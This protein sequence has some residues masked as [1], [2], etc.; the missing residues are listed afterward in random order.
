MYLDDVPLHAP[1][2]TFGGTENGYSISS[3]NDQVLRNMTLMSAAPPSAFAGAIG[4]AITAK[5]RDGSRD[6]TSF[7]GSI[8]MSDVNLLGEGPLTAA[9]R[10]SW[11]VAGRRSHLAYVTGQLGG[12]SDEKI[13][14]SDV[15]GKITYNLTS[16]HTLS[17]NVLAGDSSF[18]A[19]APNPG[20]N[21]GGLPALLSRSVSPTASEGST[22]VVKANWR[23]APATTVVI[24]TAAF[25]RTRD[26]GRSDANET[27]AFSRYSDLGG[28]TNVSWFWT[29]MSPLR[30]GYGAHMSSFVPGNVRELQNV[31]ERAV[32]LTNGRVLGPPI[33]STIR[34]VTPSIGTLAEAERKHNVAALRETNGTV[35]GWN[36]AAARLGIPRTTLIA[37][38]QRLGLSRTPVKRTKRRAESERAACDAPVAP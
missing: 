12:N 19:G 20:S 28:Q 34:P 32:S 2:H 35:G 3:L 24:N 1:T 25:Q 8:G 16:K 31:I 21:P 36:G 5:T 15:Q 13:V 23:Y 7:H 9:K 26:D 22:E 18:A 6:R 29:P 14:F 33:I 30:L 37:K 4:A 17:L 10:G 27:L 11:L 38:M